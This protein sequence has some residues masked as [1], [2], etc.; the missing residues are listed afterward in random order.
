MDTGSTGR[1]SEADE[2][3]PVALAFVQRLLASEGL[4]YHFEHLDGQAASDADAA[5]GLA[6]KARHVMVITD[7]LV[8]PLA[9][10]TA[11]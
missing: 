9:G 1:S 5:D 2:E 10:N 3:A 7:R 4:S 8:Q 11:R 6:S